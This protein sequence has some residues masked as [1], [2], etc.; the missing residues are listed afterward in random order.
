M[1]GDD[2]ILKFDPAVFEESR[3]NLQELGDRVVALYD[4]YKGKS[5]FFP[6]GMF[7]SLYAFLLI[8]QRRSN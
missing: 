5:A 3:N 1:V 8:V 7:C 4:Q 2:Y 6:L